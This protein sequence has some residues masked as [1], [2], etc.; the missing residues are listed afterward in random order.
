VIAVTN[1]RKQD[2]PT[3]FRA[4]HSHTLTDIVVLS[5]YLTVEQLPDQVQVVGDYS[6]SSLEKRC[7][8]DVYVARKIMLAINS[9]PHN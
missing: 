8:E 6:C 9:A 3:H 4:R 2:C 7:T 1:L 5:E